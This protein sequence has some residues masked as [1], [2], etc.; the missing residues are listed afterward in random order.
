MA[1]LVVAL[2]EGGVLEAVLEL[3]RQRSR[4]STVGHL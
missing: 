2:A 1:A 4:Y 3:E